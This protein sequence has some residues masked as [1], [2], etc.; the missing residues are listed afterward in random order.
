MMMTTDTALAIITATDDRSGGT[1]QQY[2]AAKSPLR[3]RRRP[4]P[5]STQS[6]EI[7]RGSFKTV[8]DFDCYCFAILPTIYLPCR[9]LSPV[10]LCLCGKRKNY[11]LIYAVVRRFEGF[12]TAMDGTASL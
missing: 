10:S 3:R 11:I 4:T 1:V 2:R 9:M 12:V 6:R 5:P 7:D 8:F